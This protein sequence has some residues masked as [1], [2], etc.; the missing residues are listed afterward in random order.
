MFW[1][2]LKKDLRRKK[3]MNVILLLFVVLSAMF[4]AASIN[5]IIAVNGGID[6]YF[7]LAEV[8]DAVVQIQEK[9]D[10]EDRIRALPSV[11]S[12]KTE[13]WH[14]VM[15]S[16]V[17]IYKGKPMNNFFN[18]ACIM[19]EDEMAIKYFDE[20]N[21]V[22]TDV[23][24]GCFY[25]T[26][27]FSQ[28]MDLKIGDQFKMEVDDVQLDL[29]YM[30]RLKDALSSSDS[31]SG[32]MLLFSNEDYDAVADKESLNKIY[33]E[34][35]FVDSTDIQAIRD[36][37]KDYDYISVGTRQDFKSIYL[38]DMIVAYIMMAISVLLMITAFVV[39]RFTIGFTISEEFREIGVM[40]AMGIS[41]GSIRAL[42]LVKYLAI[43]VI[44]A[45]IGAVLSIP[46]SGLM[47]KS[48]S[49]NMVIKNDNTSFIGLLSSVAVVALILFFC[50]TCTRKVKK[51]S[52]IDAVRSGQTGERFHKKS[53]LK[54]SRSKLPSTQ[55]MAVND[56]LSSPKNYG[57]ITVIFTLCMLMMMLMSNFA[58]TLKSEKIL[59]LFA[60]PE[61]EAFYFDTEDLGDVMMDQTKAEPFLEDMEDKLK[62]N[63]MPGKCTMMN[64]MQL[65]T[66][67]GDKEAKLTC[68]LPI[69]TT[70]EYLR[71]DEGYA[72]MN[73]DEMAVTISTLKSLDAKVGDRVTMDING[74][75]RELIITGRFSGFYTNGAILSDKFDYGN[76]P[77]AGTMGVAIHFD[78]APDKETIRSNIDKLNEIY[79]TD[80]ILTTSEMIKN[81]TGVSD[82]LNSIKKMI[83]ILTIVVT[84][85][86]VVLMERSF[87]SKEKSE[88][89]LMKA[90]G[91][92]NGSMIAQHT[93]RFGLI[94]A[95]AVLLGLAVIMP[96]GNF[97]FSKICL[98][99]GD[100]S[101]IKCAI[102]PLEIFL[103]FPAILI[104]VT[105]V[106]AL[107]T[108]L[109]TRTIKASDTA[110]IE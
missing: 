92:S 28:D 13:H 33:F 97:M 38:Y 11:S 82:T 8:P 56:V 95:A 7:E 83:M 85:L 35:L 54:L 19:S 75:Q 68:M 110:S 57:I 66:K 99:I 52:P 105:V 71:M 72:P 62:E 1:R 104:T 89:A 67:H 49:K 61:S 37:A 10:A 32:P 86:I 96:L 12:V 81:M 4:A 25:A 100:V 70:A 78:G 42:Y 101:D 76:M 15:S 31:A 45:L 79:D 65:R 50:Y 108:A 16:K 14:A 87:I 40:K 103:I 109:Y 94:A 59:W 58:V 6:Q 3:T 43:S 23:E 74:E 98:L 5:N 64:V 20:N 91:V 90:M 80:K 39:L 106:G 26:A 84:A 18:P 53:I 63:G 46:L 24:K 9:C 73:A 36:I 48:I 17:F 30:G 41:N 27:P 55:F 51:L 29:K 69:R 22:I 60:L 102:D 93:L 47:M 44:G 77:A 34:A 21:D 2:I 88:I 107:M